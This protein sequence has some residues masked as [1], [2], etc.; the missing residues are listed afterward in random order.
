MCIRDRKIDILDNQHTSAK[1]KRD[2]VRKIGLKTIAKA[3]GV[4]DLEIAELEKRII[5]LGTLFPDKNSSNETPGN[6]SSRQYTSNFGL[7]ENQELKTPDLTVFGSSF[8]NNPNISSVPTLNIATPES[9]ELGPGDELAIS[10]WGA[11][12]NEYNSKITREGYLKIERI[13]PV[14]LSGLSISEA[15]MKLKNRLSKIYSG[16][17]SNYNKVFF[18]IT[19][20]NSR[21]I[22]INITG[23]VVAPGTY[24]SVSY[25]HLTLPTIYSV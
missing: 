10:I 16:I 2:L 15:K 14:Y 20:L 18:D 12:Q 17:N 4:S 6:Q 5:N 9:Y 23:N 19:L 7:N 25:T 1:Y 11:A 24:T 13:G 3:Q 8:F 21:S 22:V